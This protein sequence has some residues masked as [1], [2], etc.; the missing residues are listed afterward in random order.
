LSAANALRLTR[1]GIADEKLQVARAQML[2]HRQYRREQRFCSRLCE[3]DAG[4]GMWRYRPDRLWELEPVLRKRLFR[5]GVSPQ[6]LD[7][8]MESRDLVDPSGASRD[9]AENPRVLHRLEVLLDMLIIARCETASDLDPEIEGRKTLSARGRHH[10]VVI[11]ARTVI[12]DQW[13][14]MVARVRRDRGWMPRWAVAVILVGAAV[15]TWQASHDAFLPTKFRILERDGYRCQ[16]PGCTTRRCL[17]VHHIIHRSHGGPDEAWNLTVL[18]A[19]HHRHVLHM[20][21]LHVSGKAPHDLTWVAGPPREGPTWVFRG[22]RLVV[23]SWRPGGA[24]VA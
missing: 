5:F 2:T 18:C 8:E 10:R 15:Q 16:A 24:A 14:R 21:T 20:G 4:L 19:T 7:R 1:H 9:P 3:F 13:R 22:E 11:Q 6:I 23:C 12:H 17:E